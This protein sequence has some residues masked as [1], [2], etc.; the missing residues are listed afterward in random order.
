MDLFCD[1][2]NEDG[3]YSLSR[4]R[5][6]AVKNRFYRR[7]SDSTGPVF[8]GG[9]SRRDLA[10]DDPREE[11]GLIGYE[12]TDKMTPLRVRPLTGAMPLQGPEARQS[13]S[14]ARNE[15]HVQSLGK[16]TSAISCLPRTPE[17]A[18]RRD[19]ASSGHSEAPP[20]PFPLPPTR[21]RFPRYD[22][23]R[24]ELAIKSCTGDMRDSPVLPPP[25]P[26]PQS[27]TRTDVHRGSVAEAP[28]SVGS[29]LAYARTRNGDISL[30]NRDPMA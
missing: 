25:P 18:I 28:F 26:P 15:L 7:S 9:P 2:G 17:S 12:M 4:T 21:A 19:I 8:G 29:S 6:I 20:P 11:V 23:S 27:A 5:T 10:R 24:E 3:G 22:T 1:S 30:G 14:K 16:R 13:D